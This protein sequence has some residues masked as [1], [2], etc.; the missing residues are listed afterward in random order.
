[1]PCARADGHNRRRWWN[2]RAT[3]SRNAHHRAV[4]SCFQLPSQPIQLQVPRPGEPRYML[5]ERLGTDAE[6]EAFASI[7]FLT[8]IYADAANW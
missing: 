3:D 5:D 1:M 6:A 7:H 8:K 2:L 4:Q